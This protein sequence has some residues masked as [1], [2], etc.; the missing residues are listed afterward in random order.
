MI[1]CLRA[2]SSR[3]RQRC[4][5]GGLGGLRR[6]AWRCWWSM[7]REGGVW[8]ILDVVEVNDI[9]YMPA[10]DLV[11]RLYRR[12]DIAGL[13]QLLRRYGELLVSMRAVELC[14]RGTD[15]SRSLCRFHG[16]T[17][18]GGFPALRIVE[19]RRLHVVHSG[20]QGGSCVQAWAPRSFLL[21]NVRS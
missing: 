19:S 2:R 3:C 11:Q 8:T 10:S 18:I 5:S 15:L 20:G 7:R 21:H 14:G 6:F 9:R 12:A 4:S 17:H 1:G 16:C 13:R